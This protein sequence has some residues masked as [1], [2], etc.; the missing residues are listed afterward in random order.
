MPF[1]L[2][3]LSFPLMARALRLQLVA[4]L[5]DLSR[6][7][8]AVY[9]N[10]RLCEINNRTS[11]IAR[12][13]LQLLPNSHF[14]TLDIMREGFDLIVVEAMRPARIYCRVEQH[15]FDAPHGGDTLSQPLRDL[16]PSHDS[17][18]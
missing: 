4:K 10:L 9:T 11:R 16:L 14:P 12:S 5:L 2:K 6:Q 1:R 17:P 15:A 18:R 8:D 3:L 13:T 7:V